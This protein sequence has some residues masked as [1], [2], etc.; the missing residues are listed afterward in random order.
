MKIINK[1]KYEGLY[2]LAIICF[3]V[4]ILMMTN[5]GQS[6][7]GA[8]LLLGIGALFLILGFKKQKSN[9]AKKIANNHLSETSQ[10]NLAVVLEGEVIGDLSAWYTGIKDTVEIGYSFSKN[11]VV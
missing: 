4:S 2:L 9:F 7:I 1:Q 6:D 8:F 5:Y 3:V 10:L 11:T